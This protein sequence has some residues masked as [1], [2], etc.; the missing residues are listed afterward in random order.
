ML[1]H[2]LDDYL[3]LDTDVAAP[4]ATI[5]AIGNDDLQACFENVPRCR[6]KALTVEHVSMFNTPDMSAVLDR[7]AVLLADGN[8]DTEIAHT[9]DLDGVAEAQR[10]VLEDSY[11]GKLVVEP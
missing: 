9:Y 10:A 1:D 2:R 8:L 5:V 3:S 6:G 7:L 11:L 4:G